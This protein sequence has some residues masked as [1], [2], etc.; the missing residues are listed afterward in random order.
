MPRRIPIN[1][2]L[3]TSCFDVY[4][5]QAACEI[6]DDVGVVSGANEPVGPAR[7][8]AGGDDINPLAVKRASLTRRPSKGR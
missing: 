6:R 5:L 4:T 8:R 7:H 3:Y 2:V 1:D